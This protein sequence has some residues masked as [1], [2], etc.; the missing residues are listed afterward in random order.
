MDINRQYIIEALLKDESFI[1]WVIE[2]NA[3][4]DDVW[5]VWEAADPPRM[6][7]V[8]EARTIISNSLQ[9]R[10]ERLDQAS[11]NTL[12]LSIQDK[13][14]SDEKT[15]IEENPFRIFSPKLLRYAA[16][17]TVL[18]LASFFTYKFFNIRKDSLTTLSGLKE[19]YAPAGS[20]LTLHMDDGSIIK[21]NAG[22]R[23]RFPEKFSATAREVYLEGEAFFE[24]VKDRTRPFTVHT[25]SL[26]TT[27]H[28]TS[29]NINAYPEK[30]Q[31]EV[32]LVTGKV[33]VKDE[34]N[35]NVVTYLMPLERVEYSKSSRELVKSNFDPNET[36]AWN[37]DVIL[38]KDAGFDDIKTTL[39]RWYGVEFV[40]E[41]K[42]AIGNDFNGRFA[43]M[44][45][46]DVLKGI[47]F[48]LEFDF[49]IEGKKVVIKNHKTNK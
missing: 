44:P 19:E 26:Q 6:G 21:L 31:I 18:L 23:I 14:L 49:T 10:D 27:V 22:S 35:E 2:P 17:I 32:A 15:V 12:W 5:K 38:F 13:I 29:F 47:S 8:Q 28:G 20:K 48:S 7:T 37:E 40:V 41:E 42:P 46:E 3:E 33:A 1:K 25:G 24:V 16:V 45:L 30:K 36:M 39:E 4:S 11:K 43:N 9:F 34:E